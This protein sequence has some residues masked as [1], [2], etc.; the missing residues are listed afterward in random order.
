MDV[1]LEPQPDGKAVVHLVGGL[2]LQ[3]AGAVKEHLAS[4]VAQG[5][6]HLVVDLD[7]VPYMDSSGLAA[8]IGGLKATRLAGG[9]LRLARPTD[10]TAMVLKLT[11][12]NR[13]LGSY[14]TIEAALAG[15]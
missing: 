10:Q 9:D 7:G 6:R 11:N 12:L 3:T 2:D 8:L 5:Y 4:A 1:R 14:D 15:V 13:I